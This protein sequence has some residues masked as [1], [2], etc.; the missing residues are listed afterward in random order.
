MQTKIFLKNIAF[1]MVFAFILNSFLMNSIRE[2]LN[3]QGIYGDGLLGRYLLSGTY[4]TRLAGEEFSLNENALY[5]LMFI[6][7][8]ILVFVCLCIY[9]ILQKWR[10]SLFFASVI[11]AL[12]MTTYL[13]MSFSTS[14]FVPGLSGNG[15]PIGFYQIDYIFWLVIW[16]V[17]LSI[18]KIIPIH[19][20]K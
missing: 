8:T 5:A 4:E 14:S 3:F 12:I 17:I 2:G 10:F 16:L 9:T 13:Y 18:H 11:S 1:V 19:N 6:M 7:H 20:S 15:F